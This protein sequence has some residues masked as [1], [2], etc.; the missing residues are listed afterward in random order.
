MRDNPT[1]QLVKSP[2]T[3][4]V[5]TGAKGSDRGEH[6]GRATSLGH[7]EELIDTTDVYNI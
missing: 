1:R 2:G 4:Q 3:W 7:I 6:Q 5:K